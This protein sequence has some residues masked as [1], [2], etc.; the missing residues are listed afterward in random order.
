MFYARESVGY[1]VT[2]R[3]TTF[4]PTFDGRMCFKPVAM[5]E[6]IAQRA[7]CCVPQVVR[8]VARN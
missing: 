4:M 7:K 2:S 1:E 6:V 8:L 3:R 5:N